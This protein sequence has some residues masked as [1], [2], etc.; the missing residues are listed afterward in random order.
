MGP[1]GPK[2]PHWKLPTSSRRRAS[3][4]DEGSQGRERALMPYPMQNLLDLDPASLAHWLAER[5]E[6]PF[7]ARQVSRWVHQRYAA[8]VAS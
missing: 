7:R 5:G 2:P 3:T 4:T 6:K 8:D 1:M